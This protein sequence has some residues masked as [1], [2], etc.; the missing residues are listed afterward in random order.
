MK[1]KPSL[2]PSRFLRPRLLLAL[3]LAPLAALAAATSALALEVSD[4]RVEHFANP[5]GIDTAA[6]RFSWKLS[7]TTATAAP[8]SATTPATST[9]TPRGQHQTA[10]RLL[11]AS[12][13]A[14]LA[15][16]TADIWDSGVVQ[17]PATH[18]VPLDPTVKLHPNGD[19]HWKV[20]A[21][22]RAAVPTAWSAPARFSVGPLAREDWKGDWLHHPT[23]NP[24]RHI[25]FRKNLTLDAPAATAFAHVASVGNHEL[26]VNGQKASTRVLAPAI[27]HY[28]KRVLY[29]TY[30]LAPLL[31]PGQNTIALWYGPG[32][33]IHRENTHVNQALLLQ[34]DGKTTAAT[35]FTLHTDATWKT[36]ESSSREI[37]KIP[38]RMGGMGG[39]EVDGRADKTDWANPTFDDSAWP[40]AAVTT[41]LKG[42]AR[43]PELSSGNL[44]D[45]SRIAATFPAAKIT[46][47]G[48]GAYRVDMGRAFTGFLQIAFNNLQPGDTITISTSDR[49]TR[50]EHFDQRQLYIARGENGETFTNRFNFA[51]GRYVRLSGLKTAPAPTD[52]HA[53]AI[54]SAA[55][56]TGTFHS[57]SALYNTFYEVDRWTY[58]MCTIEGVTT[59]CPNRERLG[60]GAETAY[61]T[62][63]GAGLPAFD[64]G[65]FYKRNVR[66]WSDTQA[67]TGKIYATAP[68]T[69]GGAWGGPLS[70][71]AIFNLAWEH[72]LAHGDKTVLEQAYETEKKWLDFAFKK[73]SK[74]PGLPA[75]G[76]AA[77]AQGN[78]YFLG[79]WLLPGHRQEMGGEAPYYFNLT[80]LA[81]AN[82]LFLKTAAVLGKPDAELAPHR[83]RLDALRAGI[84]KKYYKG[85]GIYFTGDQVRTTFALHAGVVPTAERAAATA[86]LEKNLADKGIFDIGSFGRYPFFKTLFGDPRY[87]ERTDAILRKTTYPS[88]AHFLKEGETT[89]PECWE[90]L[91]DDSARTHTSYVGISGWFVKVLAGIE[92]TLEGPGY[93][94]FTLRPQVVNSLQHAAATLESP[95]GTIKSAWKKVPANGNGSGKETGKVIYDITVPIG[96][97][98]KLTLPVPA[99]LI[100]ENGQPLTTAPG[101][102]IL[103]TTTTELRLLS[104]TY[105]FEATGNAGL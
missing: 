21:Y 89:W 56:R 71:S 13:P 2:Q 83:Q 95:Y 92:P 23:A 17:S 38:R 104:G 8:A 28:R 93:R 103:P 35:P 16:N 15:A 84:H 99:A 54:T 12:T 5:L 27:S 41:P 94:V 40:T 39:E 96:T 22:D 86:H 73:P 64:S 105:H 88:Y 30:D 81:L 43:W 80:V 87:L 66:D 36:A 72:Y 76:F 31:R 91:N 20:T 29:V 85:H 100:T 33:T 10:Y 58:E 3:V 69:Y 46:P 50:P 18:L 82:D 11:I 9:S 1:P 77:A 60:Y 79:D 47:D 65:A 101:I 49:A 74:D 98:A 53:L 61:M 63:W 67:S 25:W 42:L 62:A 90:L 24:A 52:I 32:W 19:Y 4:L 26:Y 97:T 7:P 78:G 59:D 44:T 70:S 45:P 68:Q 37:G 6:P 102:Q 34:L 55:P 75:Y 48:P 51:S 57:S 14:L